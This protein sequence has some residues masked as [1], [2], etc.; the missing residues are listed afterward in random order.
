MVRGN[1]KNINKKTK[2]GCNV[3]RRGGESKGV[4]IR[5]KQKKRKGFEGEAR[6]GNEGG[7]ASESGF[8][9]IRGG[10]KRQRGRE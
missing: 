10:G 4:S 8:Y 9:W 7:V 2:E 1:H 3:N 6:R 5:K